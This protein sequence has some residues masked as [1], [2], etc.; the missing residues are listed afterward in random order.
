M[1]A[2]T[3]PIHVGGGIHPPRDSGGASARGLSHCEGTALFASADRRHLD[4]VVR[5]L[6][7]A[8]KAQRL[9]PSTSPIPAQSA[10]AAANALE[11]FFDTEGVPVLP[12]HVVREGLKWRDEL[13]GLSS[14]GSDIADALRAHGIAELD[15][16]AGCPADELLGFLELIDRSPDSLRTDGGLS[17]AL[18]SAGIESVRVTD[19]QLTVIEQYE[20]DAT[21]DVE[22]F[23]RRLIE[24]PEKLAAWFAAA[25]SGDPHAFEEGLMEL[26]R[27]SGP[28]GYE[29]LLQT[30]GEAFLAQD[31]DS[32]DA[33]LQLSLEAGPTKDLTG[34]M[35]RFLTSRDIAASVLGGTLGKN[36]LSLSTAL[37][38]LPLDRVAA[39]VRSEVQAMLPSA[40][41]SA[42]ETQFLHHMISVRERTD[43]EPTLVDHDTTYRSIVEASRL[44]D[45][46]IARARGAV[47]GSAPALSAASVRTLLTLLDQQRDFKLFCET[48][49]G[50]AGMVPRLIEQG[51]LRIALHALTELNNRGAVNTGPWPELSAR[52]RAALSSTATPA[53]MAA[54]VTAVARDRSLA[55]LARD[56]VRL[57]GEHAP[58][59][60]I[61]EALAHK[62]EGLEVAEEVLGRTFI[63]QLVRV[64]V[65]APWYQ[66][67]VIVTRLAREEDG[68]A[69]GVVEDLLR[70]ADEQSRRE[71]T[72]G[73]AAAG[74]PLA[75]RLLPRL[76]RDSSVEVAIVAVRA[77]GRSGMPEAGALLSGRLAE[78]DIDGADF[79]LARE[80]IAAL[81]RIPGSESDAALARLA[82]RRALIKRGH[83]AEIQDLVRQALLARSQGGAVR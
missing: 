11:V 6:S 53:A 26:V 3:N 48:A 19:V 57:A 73:L 12:L 77:V 50:L 61:G 54:L 7:S 60:F 46:A 62:G 22:D 80:V 82:G 24:D 44:S 8:A 66:L 69:S 63:D 37:T 27:V 78:L 35:F 45:E 17:A 75:A 31:A 40:G 43:P 65:A 70:R 67:S 30:L 71:V 32:R 34:G 76:L 29:R 36:M 21:E 33:L 64:A 2:A 56:V 23:L 81:A 16:M 39:Q 9:Y 41:H 10:E 13:T 59:V 28:S 1:E 15:L 38:H 5:S 51:D 14:G 42:K 20:P 72:V 68:R 52:V 4:S 83:F 47:T 79:A 74:G 58:V 18:A 55:P 25:S 49:E